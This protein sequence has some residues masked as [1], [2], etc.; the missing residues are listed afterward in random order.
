[1]VG[2]GAHNR[3]PNG[4][5]RPAMAPFLFSVGADAPTFPAALRQLPRSPRRLWA[6]GRLPAAGERLLAIVGARA[7]T[8]AGCRWAERLAAAA[9]GAGL[10]VISG[11][12]LGIDAA[13]HRGALSAG[14]ATFAVLGCGVDVVYPD[15][16][17]PLFA[18]IGA[19]GGLLSEY[20]P[21]TQ[22]RPGQFPVRN[23]IVA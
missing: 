13:S 19:A 10:G 16:H 23:R 8:A 5:T 20:A 12:A 4:P 14:G 17:A 22:P 3:S 15:R 18:E 1:M 11:G 21:G 9:V 2:F 7:S 6:T